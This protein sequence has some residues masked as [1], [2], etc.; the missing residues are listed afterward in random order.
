[1]MSSDEQLDPIRVDARPLPM[2]AIIAIT[3]FMF[4]LFAIIPGPHPFDTY[5]EPSTFLGWIGTC[6]KANKESIA[7]FSSLVTAIGVWF[8][9]LT[10]FRSQRMN[11]ANMVFDKLKEIRE[12]ASDIPDFKK[13]NPRKISEIVQFYS[14]IYLYRHYHLVTRMEWSFFENDMVKLVRW[15]QYQKWLGDNDCRN[16]T[17][18]ERGEYGKQFAS[19]LSKLATEGGL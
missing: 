9:A 19:Y 16:K 5:Q 6:L 17:A 10:F 1:M 2:S 14:S 7:A 4:L 15:W 11:R 3:V 18:L 8:A 13:Y 12:M